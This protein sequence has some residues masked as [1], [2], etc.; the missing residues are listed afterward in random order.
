MRAPDGDADWAD[1][2][3]FLSAIQGVATNPPKDIVTTKFTSGMLMGNGDIGVVAGDTTTT[4]KFYFGKGDFP[5]Q[6]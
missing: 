3:S 4:Q 5:G 1:I 2:Q 6:L